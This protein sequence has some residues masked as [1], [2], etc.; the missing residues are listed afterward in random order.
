MTDT[1]LIITRE[2]LDREFRPIF[3]QYGEGAGIPLRDLRSRLQDYGL[4]EHL[5]P[6]KL[7]LVIRRA[8]EDRDGTLDYEEFVQLILTS[9]DKI[10]T[11]TQLTAFQKS[12]R[13]A[14]SSVAPHSYRS[15]SGEPLVEDYISHYNCRPP[16][17]FMIT[18]SIVEIII[19]IVYAVELK[20]TDYE[21]TAT[22]GIP[23]Y[24][25]FIYN[26]SRRY[27][28]W[29][30][31]TYMFLHQGYMHLIFNLIFQLC[32][33][34]PLEM[35]HKWW[36]VGTVYCLGVIAGKTHIVISHRCYIRSI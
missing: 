32:L 10:L 5:P 14:V 1:E 17:L 33:G 26:P 3:A 20:G 12:V 36:R 18:V 31:L 4:G 34:L 23:L 21:I 9:E 16:P 19:F 24:S 2:E 28:A 30:Y 25:P 22:S 13:L 15:R 35:V 11:R 8:D 7:E 6:G 29:R 27:E